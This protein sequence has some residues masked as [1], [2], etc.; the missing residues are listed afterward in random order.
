MSNKNYCCE[1]ET[2]IN[3]EN[4]ANYCLKCGKPI[5]KKCYIEQTSCMHCKTKVFIAEK[6]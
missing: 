4:I 2:S 1:C 3:N 5:C 6:K